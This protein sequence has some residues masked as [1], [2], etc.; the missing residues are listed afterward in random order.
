[1]I[2]PDKQPAPVHIISLGAGVQSSTIALMAARGEIEPMPNCAIFADTQAEPASVYKWLDWLEKQLP[3]PV[4]RVTK[5][6]LAQAALIKK[7]KRDGSGEWSKSCIPAF[8]KNPDGSCGL[9]QR[10]CTSDYKVVPLTRT[11]LQ[12]MKDTGASGVVQW[13][14]ISLDEVHRMKPSRDKR[15]TNRWPLVDKKMHRWSC[16]NWMR[17]NWYPQPPRSACV[18]CPYHSDTEWRR[19]RDE[20]PEEFAKAVQFDRDYRRIKMETNN[21]HG[22]PYLHRSLVPLDQVDFS[23]DVER[24]QGL[25]WG[26]ECEG[27]CGV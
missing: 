20:E 25:L 13:I 19:L 18:Y 5:G 2:T 7:T 8:I 17:A 11:A 15:I 16:L 12:I 14:G 1:M 26:N 9:L 21:M 10:Q 27:L 23:T 4:H 6:N 24:G 3:F 22:L